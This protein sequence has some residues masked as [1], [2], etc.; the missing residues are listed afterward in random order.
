[1][2]REQPNTESE[3][4]VPFDNKSWRARRHHTQACN[5]VCYMYIAR[6]LTGLEV[7]VT[8]L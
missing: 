7:K 3:L 8:L 5:L 4:H 1:M 6:K 2:K